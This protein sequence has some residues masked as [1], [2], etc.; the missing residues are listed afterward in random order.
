MPKAC[1]NNRN[2]PKHAESNTTV[3]SAQQLRPQQRCRPVR[4]SRRSP[5]L[6]WQPL[7]FPSTC[8]RSRSWRRSSSGSASLSRRRTPRCTATSPT[9]VPRRR[10]PD[11]LERTRS[12]AIFSIVLQSKQIKWLRDLSAL[13]SLIS[14]SPLTGR[15]RRRRLRQ[16]DI[17]GTWNIV[18]INNTGANKCYQ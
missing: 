11:L 14:C 12:F 5:P 16:Q 7:L 1:R 13:G 15:C 9:T 6:G 18:K 3:A 4:C 2:M 8:R 10:G 17:F